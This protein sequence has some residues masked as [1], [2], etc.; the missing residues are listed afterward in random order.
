MKNKRIIALASAG[1]AVVLALGGTFAAKTVFAAESASITNGNTDTIL[2]AMVDVEVMKVY[3]NSFYNDTGCTMIL[4]TGYVASDS[5]KGMYLA[6]R[7]P[8]DSSNVYYTVSENVDAEAVKA[9]M[10]PDDYKERVEKKF[11]ETYGQEASV[12]SCKLTNTETDG[13]PTYKIEL[14]CSAGDM[15]ME[16]L[17]YIIMADKTYTITYSQSADD[18]RMEEFKKSAETIHMVFS[19]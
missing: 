18:E 17:T 6:E 8:L 3:K 1:I 15:K 9:M 12:D 10:N 13:C 2:H 19:E 14:S 11:K 5:I 4:P 16:Q 7:H